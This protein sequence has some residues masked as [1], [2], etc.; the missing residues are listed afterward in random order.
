MARKRDI[1]Q[2]PAPREYWARAKPKE[3]IESLRVRREDYWKILEDMG[4]VD[5]AYSSWRLYHGLHYATTVSGTI[6]P[7]GEQGEVDQV[8]VNQYRSILNLLLTYTLSVEL[9]WDAQ[10]QD[11]SE[12]T[13]E[14]TRFA[15]DL[16]DYLEDA[17]QYGVLK[18]RKK[19]A[20]E[21]MIFRVGYVSTCWDENAGRVMGV[22]DEKKKLYKYSGALRLGNP[23]LLDVFSDPMVL[24]HDE[25]KW[26]SWRERVNRYDT[27]ETYFD[28]RDQILNV[29]SSYDDEDSMDRFHGM[30]WGLVRPECQVDLIDKWHFLHLPTRGFP[31]G[32][33][34]C[35][36]GEV[37]LYDVPCPPW[38][39]RLPIHPIFYAPMLG[40]SLVG[41]SPGADIGPLQEALNRVV[42]AVVTNQR[43]FGQQKLW[44]QD[45]MPV[46]LAE[47]EPGADVLRCNVPPQ[48]LNLLQSAPEL[49]QSP[50]MLVTM[51]GQ[52]LSVS[53]STRG[54][55]GRETSG[56]AMAFQDSKTLAANSRFDDAYRSL[57]ASVGTSIL[58]IMQE[59][60]T[61]PVQIPVVSEGEVRGMQAFTGERLK[62]VDRILIKQGTAALRTSG[63]RLHV[64]ELLTQMPGM[65]SNPREIITVMQTGNLDPLTKAEDAQRRLIA[66]ENLRLKMGELFDCAPTD[67]HIGHIKGH[68]ADFASLQARQDTPAGRAY[69]AHSMTHIQRIVLDPI[70]QGL[71]LA[72][73]W[74]TPEQLAGFQQLAPMMAGMGVPGQGPGG[75]SGQPSPPQAPAGPKLLETPPGQPEGLAPQAQ[76][77]LQGAQSHLQNE[78]AK[79]ARTTGAIK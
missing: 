63:E 28:K 42:S 64:A 37:D 34:M 2:T 11:A 1:R 32:R 47:L 23:S 72:Q 62:A 73:G 53:D 21:S 13:L 68:G 76:K 14:A 30:D 75:V 65:L 8:A 55:V 33:Y 59:C 50:Q 5:A 17:P 52:L 31:G 6:V 9:D 3:L 71:M 49:L 66:D 79:S 74:C 15:N 4:A 38:Y 40:T 70:S 56:V 12:K 25:R 27:A 7:G 39:K 43:R 46:S 61:D 29:N 35:W 48:V 58:Q 22:A 36:A 44:M 60:L 19:A 16:M 51:M 26:I 54:V 77:S 24:E 78:A 57:S 69:V 20:E 67:D 10:A 41:H 45:G 18:K